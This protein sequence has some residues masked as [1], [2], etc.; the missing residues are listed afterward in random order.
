MRAAPV[1]P[2][3]RVSSSHPLLLLLLY[4]MSFFLFPALQLFW[5]DD[6]LW[7]PVRIERLDLPARTAK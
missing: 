7:Y 6:G 2:S 3:H 1:S 5:P 4:L